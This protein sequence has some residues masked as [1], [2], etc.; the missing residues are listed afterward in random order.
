MTHLDVVIF[1][2]SLQNRCKS[3]RLELLAK[4]IVVTCTRKPLLPSNP[5]LDRRPVFGHVT[6]APLDD[7]HLR[8]SIIYLICIL[9]LIT[10]NSE[11]TLK[12]WKLSVDHS[13]CWK[14]WL[15]ICQ[16]KPTQ[17]AELYLGY[18]RGT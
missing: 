16:E 9:H 5:V 2:K 4:K 6:G 15:Q 13:L 14:M 18:T 11:I 8:C 12:L 17:T 10:L 1:A 7:F 3:E